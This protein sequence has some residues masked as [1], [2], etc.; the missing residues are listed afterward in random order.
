MATNIINQAV[1]AQAS[2]EEAFSALTI[3]SNKQSTQDQSDI[4]VAIEMMKNIVLTKDTPVLSPG[5]APIPMPVFA[6]DP[7][8]YCCASLQLLEPI[9]EDDLFGDSRYDLPPHSE[10]GCEYFNAAL[11]VNPMKVFDPKVEE[12][13]ASIAALALCNNL[14]GRKPN[15]H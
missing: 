11:Q 6:K 10:V 4:L 3:E 13:A 5:S 7:C 14:K 9:R 8:P 1:Q 2:L 15:S 12:L